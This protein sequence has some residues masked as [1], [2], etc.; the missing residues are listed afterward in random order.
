MLVKMI[1]LATMTV[2]AIL[3]G[4]TEMVNVAMDISTPL[5][6][7]ARRELRVIKHGNPDCTNLSNPEVRHGEATEDIYVRN[8]YIYITSRTNFTKV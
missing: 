5:M 7:L 1:L 3:M 6:G 4:S 2:L 8:F